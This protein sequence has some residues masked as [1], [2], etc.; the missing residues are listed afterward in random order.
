MTN[1]R[2]KFVAVVFI[3]FTSLGHLSANA[4]AD[5]ETR[6][7]SALF[8]R[9]ETVVYTRTD[10]LVRSDGRDASYVDSEN[11]LRVPYLELITGLKAL[12]PNT[13][14]DLEKSYR[15]VLVGAKD[16][17][18]SVLIAGKEFAE[19]DG[20]GMISF[21]KCYLG[22]LESGAQPKLEQDFR[23][24]S[25]ESIEGRKVWIWLVPSAG[26]DSR[27][28]KFYAAQIAGSY[29]V[30]ANNLQDFKEVAN[31]LTST[32][33]STST[34]ISVPGWKIFSSHKYW[35]Y[36]SIR[37]S[38]ATSASVTGL[39]DLTR[40]VI[41][42]TFFADIDRREAFILVFSSDRSMRKVPTVLPEAELYRLQPKEAGIW[43]AT[44]PLSKD[45][46][47]SNTLFRVF[48]HFGFAIAL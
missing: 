31:A 10:F 36:R 28:I 45:E 11:M 37:W 21:R 42:L 19:P 13:A 20:P 48:Y 18:T 39:Q 26:K 35:V 17:A 6:A 41:A 4:E 14:S 44:I 43:Q 9:F 38:G 47:G 24:A 23:Q 30:I 27:P 3:V 40:D 15:T 16:F 2:T 7:A 22:V 33:S 5:L 25:Y 34:P 29:F 32:E 12:G 1:R 46:E 8:D